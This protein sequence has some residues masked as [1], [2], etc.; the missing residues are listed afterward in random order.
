MSRYGAT[1]TIGRDEACLRETR[2]DDSRLRISRRIAT[3]TTLK[4]PRAQFSAGIRGPV[5]VLVFSAMPMRNV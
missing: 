2:F 3:L 1:T 5:A 4:R